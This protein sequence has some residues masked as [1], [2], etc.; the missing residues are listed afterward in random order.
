[1]RKIE[2]KEEDPDNS[3]ENNKRLRKSSVLAIARLRAPKFWTTEARPFVTENRRGHWN[4]FKMSTL[5]IE[6]REW[7]ESSST[8]SQHVILNCY[9]WQ[10]IRTI[11]NLL[12][13]HS[14]RWLRFKMQLML[15]ML[16]AVQRQIKLEPST[17]A[18]ILNSAKT[19]EYAVLLLSHVS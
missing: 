17:H 19:I 12:S 7:R 5:K 2:R 14:C 10:R 11:F 13:A 18:H 9:Q 3:G 15:L 8:L 4:C 1:M 6:K 16:V